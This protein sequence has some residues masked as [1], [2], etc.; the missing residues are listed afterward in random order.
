MCPSCIADLI[1]E[2]VG[3]GATIGLERSNAGTAI[4]LKDCDLRIVDA[5]QPVDMARA[6]KSIE[7]LKCIMASLRAT[8]IGIGKPRDAIRPSMTE[9]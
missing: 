8:E 2:L 7:E 9:N 4:A 5:K 1:A 3:T 6:I